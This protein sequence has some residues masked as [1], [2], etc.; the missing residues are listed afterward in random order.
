MYLSL[1][2]LPFLSFILC[3]FFGRRVG[4]NGTRIISSFLV[5]ISLFLSLVVFYDVSETENF[6]YVYLWSWFKT[7]MLE[8]QLSLSFDLIACSTLVLVLSVSFLVHLFSTSYMNHDPHLPRFM[9][10]LSLFTFFMVV[11][12]TSSNLVQLFIGWEGVGLCSYLL[13]N[14]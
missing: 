6:S 11:L 8:C 9:S 5:L 3:S 12:I 2:I 14:F 4:D 7:G 13:I 1:I 10:Y